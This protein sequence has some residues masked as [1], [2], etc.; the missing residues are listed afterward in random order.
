MVALAAQQHAVP[1]VVC[2]GLY[3]LTPL[4]PSATAEQFNL[5][6]SPQVVLPPSFPTSFPTSPR[7]LLP[8]PLGLW[9]LMPPR[10][11]W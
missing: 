10:P 7:V 5:L 2:A 1:L 9:V 6:L 4:F 11:R 8:L 3:K